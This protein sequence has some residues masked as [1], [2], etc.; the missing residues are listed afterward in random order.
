MDP[1]EEVM[2]T[3]RVASSHY[4]RMELRA[5]FGI[6]FDTAAQARLVIITRGSCIA[7]ADALPRPLAL[8]GGTA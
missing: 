1:L 6:R 7:V 2:T 8:T 5:P 4:V 3:M